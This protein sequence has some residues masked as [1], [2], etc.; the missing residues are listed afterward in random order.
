VDVV[1]F[2][3][4]NWDFCWTGKQQLMTRLAARGHRVLYVDPDLD[5]ENP[6]LTDVVRSVAPIASGLAPRAIAPRLW[7]LTHRY[8]PI[9]RWRLSVRRTDGV[10]R[11]CLRRLGLDRALCLTQ[12]PHAL[13]QTD[14]VPFAARVHYAIDE[15]TAFGGMSALEQRSIRARETEL[16]RRS[17]RTLAI[18]PRLVARLRAIQAD[19]HLL[20]SGADVEHFAPAR[21]A[22]LAPLPALA[23]L[24]RPLLGFVGQIDERLDA[25]LVLAVLRRCGG[26]VVLAGHVKRG[27][28]V[29]TLR[30]CAR[31]HFL[32]HLSYDKLPSLLR[33]ID[34]CLVPFRR[35]A[36]T[37]SSSPLKVYEYLAAGKPVV[38]VP[39]DGLLD[40]APVVRL[41]ERAEDFAR[42]V[43]DCLA[44]PDDGRDRRL[45][46][47][48]ANSWEH[49]CDA[50]EAHLAAVLVAARSGAAAAGAAP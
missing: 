7:V 16:V 20:P 12:W 6:A 32:G 27:V 5:L 43:A 24:P 30:A 42:A 39:L 38:S 49:R 50:L 4:Q 19:T 44:D 18:S 28:D 8:S 13:A 15:M 29:S 48:A 9:L 3:Q 17:R 40:C 11:R 45:A 26:S 35:N 14:V 25:D 41:A 47:A 33:D 46:V 37:E 21:A 2:G 31:V 34:V 23:S 1:C 10:L 36:L 22:A